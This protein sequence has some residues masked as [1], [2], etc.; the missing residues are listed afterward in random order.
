M[1]AELVDIDRALV[2]AIYIS[3]LLVVVVPQYDLKRC[4]T[5]E[6]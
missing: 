3:F 6:P 4:P 2:D 5:K 1:H